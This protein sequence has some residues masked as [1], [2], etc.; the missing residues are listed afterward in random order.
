MIDGC[1]PVSCIKAHGTAHVRVEKCRLP[2]RVLM[3]DVATRIGV[4]LRS[5]EA[6]L[7]RWEGRRR[8]GDCCM[9]CKSQQPVCSPHPKLPELKPCVSV[10]HACRPR[11]LR[12]RCSRKCNTA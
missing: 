9:S 2:A 11:S 5:Q 10:C 7:V 3:R 12:S 6:Q 8:E 1:H 4:R